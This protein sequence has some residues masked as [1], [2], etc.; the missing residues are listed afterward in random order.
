LIFRAMEV[1]LIKWSK[2]VNEIWNFFVLTLNHMRFNLKNFFLFIILYTF[3]L[4]AVEYI[5]SFLYSSFGWQMY[6]PVPGGNYSFFKLPFPTV[7]RY[8]AA[9]PPEM[10]SEFEIKMNYLGIL[11]DALLLVFSLY[12]I[13]IK[14]IKFSVWVILF[15]VISFLTVAYFFISEIPK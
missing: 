13:F 3:I 6:P 4:F 5:I 14:K 12:L 9:L 2:Q 15:T 7:G 11:L 1:I 10:L 8:H